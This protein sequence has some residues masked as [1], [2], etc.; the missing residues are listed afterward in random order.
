MY[1]KVGV[2]L[3]RCIRENRQTSVRHVAV[4]VCACGTDQQRFVVE[5][6]FRNKL[7]KSLFRIDQK[8]VIMQN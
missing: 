3:A 8:W 2:D 7:Y 6:L 5:K 4:C 1:I